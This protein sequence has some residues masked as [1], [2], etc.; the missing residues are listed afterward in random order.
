MT[1]TDREQDEFGPTKRPPA[2]ESAR[3]RESAVHAMQW[4]ADNLGCDDPHDLQSRGVQV[5]FAPQIRRGPRVIDLSDGRVNTLREDEH[6]PDL[7]Y[8]A[9]YDSLAAYCRRWGVPMQE[10]DGVVVLLPRR[11]EAGD[12]LEHPG[13]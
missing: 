8:F 7:G 11:G 3:V 12:P 6:A 4:A 9:E 10:V 2:T 5:Y 13:A 1:S